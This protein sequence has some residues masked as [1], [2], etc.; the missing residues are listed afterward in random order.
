MF[1]Y[2]QLDHCRISLPWDEVSCLLVAT[3]DVIV[4]IGVFVV[5]SWVDEITG[6]VAVLVLVFGTEVV[7]M[8]VELPKLSFMSKIHF[9]WSVLIT[10]QIIRKDCFIHICVL[11]IDHCKISLPW[12]EVSCVLVATVDVIV[13][14]G[15]FVVVSCVEEITGVVTVLALVFGAVVVGMLVELPK[16]SFM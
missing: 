12:D 7:G 4:S 8:L 11:S 10:Y 16:I 13:S 9:N 5:V 1:V 15:I 2:F 14:M 6:V 3:V